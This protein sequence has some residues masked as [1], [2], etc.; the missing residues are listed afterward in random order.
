M[1]VL[2]AFAYRFESVDL[3]VF[4]TL[5]LLEGL[6]SFDNAAVLAAMVRRLPPHQRRKA[7]FYGLLGAYAF[8]I[9][10]ILLASFL[11][12]STLLRIVGGTYLIYLAVRHIFF[13]AQGGVP[14][15]AR[16]FLG[17]SIF[18]STV[19]A[20]EAADLVFALDQ[21]VV[22]VALT[23]KIPLIIAAS[24]LAILALRLSATYMVRLMDWFP[25]LEFFAYLAVYW[26]GAKLLVQE[27]FDVRIP[28]LLSLGVT[29]SLLLIPLL[30]KTVLEWRRR[31]RTVR[32]P[33][34]PVA[35]QTH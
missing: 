32:V 4:F 2:D 14:T 1:G 7:L 27:F 12:E 3:A 35:E 29:L 24:L 15:T 9:T 19:I 13:Q 34:P 10:A 33:L 25:S 20:I 18:W 30:V 8:R 28:K 26:V 31:S 11:I 5:I 17:F 21:I 6:L 22:A 16:S 23:Q